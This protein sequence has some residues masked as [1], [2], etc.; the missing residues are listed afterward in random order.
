MDDFG[1][2]SQA[3]DELKNT[4]ETNESS[5]NIDSVD[6]NEGTET[7]IRNEGYESSEADNFSK[8]TEANEMNY[9]NNSNAMNEQIIYK[10]KKEKKAPHFMFVA[11]ISAVIGGIITG[12]AFFVFL[13]YSGNAAFS[14]NGT[15]KI[16]I[17]KTTSPVVEIAKKVGPSVVSIK[18]Q[19]LQN[20]G[21]FGTTQ[22][23]PQGS[24]IIISSDGYI[25]TNYHV[26]ADALG[27]D[28]KVS[29]TS[30]IE[31]YILGN[32]GKAYSANFV[33]GDLKTDLAVLKINKTGLSAADL[34]DSSALQVGELV[35]A[36]GSPGGT[37]LAGS[38]SEG[39]VSGLN[40]KVQTEGG[41]VINLIQTDTAISPGN[42]GGA[43]VNSQGQVVGINEL[44]VV[45]TG[46][47]GICFS[48]PINSAKTI[49]NSLI[50]NGFIE[51][52]YIGIYRNADFDEAF[53]KANNYPAGV[54]VDSVVP[55]SGAYY[56]GIKS[57]D[58]IT[59]FNGVRIN[60][61]D[62]LNAEK[63]KTKVGQ[64]VPV[65]VYRGGKTIKL[66]LKMGA[67]KQ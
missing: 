3:T 44:K 67:T 20:D 63:D 5:K 33:G 59:K 48:I 4:S 43:L 17:Q 53:A 22:V 29:G 34:G 62:D 56:A 37:D 26:I 27:N 23:E 54:L 65:E 12:G 25:V 15:T 40:R 46:F 24:G 9:M 47:E 45:A 32:T 39:I 7:S 2:K 8:T 64:A 57:Q 14:N 42:S 51:R 21:I 52:P 16:Q 31:V 28:G 18:V 11:I 60:N 30:K 1:N 6:L 49:I 58:I 36:I 19:A 13:T 50:K 41:S 61:F 55:L 10:P 66:S 38:V 35:V